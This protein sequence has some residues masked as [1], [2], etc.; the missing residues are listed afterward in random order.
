MR[1]QP[2]V[3][4]NISTRYIISFYYFAYNYIP[5]FY[6]H[7]FSYLSYYNCTDEASAHGICL[8][9]WWQQYIN[10]TWHCQRLNT[11]VNVHEIKQLSFTARHY[12][13]FSVI[14]NSIKKYCPAWQTSLP[15]NHWQRILATAYSDQRISGWEG[16]EWRRFVGVLSK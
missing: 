8:H 7:I 16:P 4:E 15:K 9:W 12:N 2:F 14:L 3:W 10:V 11:D 5:L 6:L 1:E 13:I